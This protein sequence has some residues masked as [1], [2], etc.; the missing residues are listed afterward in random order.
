MSTRAPGSSADRWSF[1]RT[2]VQLACAAVL[3]LLAAC[4]A[5]QSA[6]RPPNIVVVLVD[7][8]GWRDLSFSGQEWVRTPRL[9][10]L[11]R[12]GL[13]FEQA[14]AAN[15]VCSPTRAALL[16]GKYPARIGIHDWIPGD[17]PG[18]RSLVPPSDLDQLPLEHTTTAEALRARG[19][20]TFH[21]GKWHLGGAGFLPQ[22][23][24]FDVNWMGRETGHPASHHSP[25]GAARDGKPAASH[26]V[27]PLSRPPQDGEYLAD[28]QISDALELA[29]GSVRNGQ[30][31]YIYLPLYSVHAPIEAKAATI[32]DHKRWRA[33]RIAASGGTLSEPRLPGVRYAAMLEDMDAACGRLLDG[34]DSIGVGSDTL[35]LL[36]SDNGGLATISDNAPLRGG[37][38]SLWEGGLRVPLIVRWPGSVAPGAVC[39]E[40]VISQ[41]VH[42]T[43][44]AVAGAQA[45]ATVRE[46]ARSLLPLLRGEQTAL[47]PRDLY[48]HF[49]QYEIDGAPPRGA[50]RSGRW[51]LHESF[52]DGS[53]RLY[54]L[55]ADPGESV[56]L[57]GSNPAVAAELVG[58]LRSWRAKVGAAMPV[59][60]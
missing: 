53:V 5:P 12:E 25:W 20:A 60:R 13:R 33:G 29:R 23:Q 2:I 32:E 15:P 9:D 38:R 47:A 45:D 14:Y 3:A 26:E 39:R 51:K 22:D 40:P 28:R 57:A 1:P 41:D 58:R 19:Y 49:P 34:L 31:F 37:K 6:S 16:T 24:G 36:T 56:D 48:W 17:P 59:P 18:N 43:L 8:L 27:R 4:A 10:A 11:A 35:I 21:V 54:D 52:V 46:D 42:A 30:P 44:C 50:L 7:D 55:D